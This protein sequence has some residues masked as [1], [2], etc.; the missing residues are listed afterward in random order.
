MTEEKKTELLMSEFR[1]PTLGP[2]SLEHVLTNISEYIKSEPN[3]RYKMIIGTDSQGKNGR[4]VD[5]ITAIIIHRIGAGGVYFWQRSLTSS[6][7]TLRER[8]YREALLSVEFA[9]DLLEVVR[10]EEIL[11]CNLEIHLDVGT[12]GETREIINEVV[13]IIRGSGFEVRTKPDSFGA[14]KIADRHT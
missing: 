3:F 9:T 8:I 13:G 6:F 2:L 4:L 14:S 12:V 7:R 1:S 10:D 5:F 11:G